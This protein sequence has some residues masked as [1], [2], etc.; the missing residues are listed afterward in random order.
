MPLIL[1][2]PEVKKEAK[3][4]LEH[5]HDIGYVHGIVK[6]AISVNTGEL[7]GAALEKALAHKLREL[8]GGVAW[9]KDWQIEIVPMEGLFGLG[10]LREPEFPESSQ[11]GQQ[12]RRI[13]ER[14]HF[15]SITLPETT[16]KA[17][18]DRSSFQGT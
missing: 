10:L 8:L 5:V 4:A 6:T 18:K 1:H 14:R 11:T 9:L 3:I 12:T 16:I 15:I 2:L 17:R 13:G 7:K